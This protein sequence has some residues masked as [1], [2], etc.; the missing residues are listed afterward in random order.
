MLNN[1]IV[2]LL[3]CV[4]LFV[5]PWT[6]AC[7]APSSSTI[8]WSLLKFMPIELVMLFNHLNILV[9]A[10]FCNNSHS[11]FKFYKQQPFFLRKKYRYSKKFVSNFQK[12][13]KKLLNN[14]WVTHEHTSFQ[15]CL[16]LNWGENNRLNIDYMCDPKSSYPFW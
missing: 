16:D 4:R 8:S 15:F 13:I 1:I 10:K 6:V 3:S 9:L 5:I 14:Y 12:Y 7:Q 11:T 2:Q